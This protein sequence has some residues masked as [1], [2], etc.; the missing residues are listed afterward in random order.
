MFGSFKL[1][2]LAG[3]DIKVHAT[4]AL[5][6]ILGASQW[7]RFGA[8]GAIFG[9]LMTALLFACVLLHELGH[10]MVAKAFGI[11]V[12]TITLYPFGGVAQ[13]ASKPKTPTHELLI[14]LAGPLVNVVIALGLLLVG[15][16]TIGVEGMTAAWN[17]I[18]D[19]WPTTATLLV[20]LMLSNVVLAVFN[21]IPALPMD[22]GRVFRALLSYPLGGARA[23]KISALVGKVIAAAM[24]AFGLVTM[25]V[26][27]MVIGAFVFFGAG[28][29]AKA[30][31]LGAALGDVPAGQAVNPRAIVLEP[32]ATLGE[33]LQS[34]VSTGQSSFAVLHFGRLVGVIS[35]P[36]VMAALQVDGPDGYVT[37][38]MRREV[39]VVDVGAKL[40]AARLAMN[41]ALSPVAAVFDGERFVGLISEVELAQQALAA[42]I[43]RRSRPFGGTPRY[44]SR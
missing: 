22:G 7:V 24:F 35:K 37:G 43:L 30:E 34:I 9:A 5:A 12:P 28:Q 16:L 13:M 6:L 19:A 4:F 8:H 36:Q 33:V 39:P 25:N 32:A 38:V 11:A 2:R 3:I 23:T 44:Q 31:Q 29:E 18:N 42:E 41:T 15:R 26:M 14:S 20:V 1:A 10:S 17:G 40:E 21:M 27:L